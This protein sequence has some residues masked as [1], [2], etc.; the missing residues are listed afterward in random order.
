[1]IWQVIV[2]SL[3]A[4]LL[5]S[6][7]LSIILSKLMGKGDI[8]EHGSGNAGTTNTLRTLGKLPAAAVLIWDILKGVIAVLL[9]K[10]IMDLTDANIAKEIVNEY[11]DYAMALSAIFAVLGHNFPI[12][13]GFKGGKGVATSLGVIIA[14]EWPIAVA[15]AIFAIVMIILTRMV[16]V[17]SVLVAILYPILTFCVGD[18]FTNK[19]IYLG[20][21]LLLAASVLI[22]HKANIKRI[23]NGTENKLWKTKEEKQ[24]ESA[25]QNKEEK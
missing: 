10:W 19:W 9:A 4:Y 24:A 8:R 16:S 23:L 13:F 18:E 1:M 15:C 14:I 3:I 11:R 17:G 5:G 21:A 7:N 6:V 2:A 20:L 12:Y 25:T 22:R